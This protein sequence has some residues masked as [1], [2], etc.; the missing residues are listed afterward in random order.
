MSAASFRTAELDQ[1]AK[2]VSFYMNDVPQKI[3]VFDK[4]E[5]M[6]AGAGPRRVMVEF[7]LLPDVE[8][9]EGAKVD[10]LMYEITP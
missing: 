3:Y 4:L 2:W 7:K 5:M 9:I 10:A 6:K 1:A 8:I